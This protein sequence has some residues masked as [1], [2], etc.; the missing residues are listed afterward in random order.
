[1]RIRATAPKYLPKNT[2]VY[3]VRTILTKAL[4]EEAIGS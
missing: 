2:P 3:K 4:G 1:M